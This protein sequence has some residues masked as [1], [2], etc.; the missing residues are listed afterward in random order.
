MILVQPLHQVIRLKFIHMNKLAQIALFA[1][2]LAFA[3]C[4]NQTTG[5]DQPHAHDHTEHEGHDHTAGEQLDAALDS[6]EQAGDE[7]RA[8]AE[9]LGED[10]KSTF[11]EAKEGVKAGIKNAKEEVKEASKAAAQDVKNAAKKVGEEVNEA[12]KDVKN[13]LKKKD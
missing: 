8:E 10:T 1:G 11:Q 9:T 4:N 3:S 13:D 5:D 7:I 6:M 2:A 12:A